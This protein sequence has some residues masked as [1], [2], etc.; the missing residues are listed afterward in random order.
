MTFFVDVLLP[1]LIAAM[2]GGFVTEFVR[3]RLARSE[4]LEIEDSKITE[5]EIS[6]NQ[7]RDEFMWQMNRKLIDIEQAA[8]KEISE[9]KERNFRQDREIADLKRDLDEAM[10]EAALARRER[11]N[12]ETQLTITKAGLETCRDELRR[13]KNLKPPNHDD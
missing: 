10:E 12:L 4:R 11:A 8:I 3:A 2:G 1:L 6:A 13:V 9:L 7:K 5:A